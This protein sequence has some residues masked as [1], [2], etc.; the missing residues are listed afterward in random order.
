MIKATKPDNEQERLEALERYHILDTLP[1]EDYDN[2]TELASSICGTKISLITLVDNNRQFFKSK[3]GIDITETPRDIAFCAHAIH[4]PE[5]MMIVNDA[6]VDERFKDN[7]FVKENPRIGFYAGMPLVTQDGFALGTLC[8]LDTKPKVLKLDQINS[9]KRLTKLVMRLL[10]LRQ[11]TDDLSES[12]KI[13]STYQVQT[14]QLIFTI[15]HD[16]KSPV[17]SIYSFLSLLKMEQFSNLNKESR[18]YIEYAFQSSEQMTS[19]INEMLTF[20]KIGSKKQTKEIVNSEVIIEDIVKLNL[21]EIQKEN[22]EITYHD[23]NDIKTQKTLFSIVL[24]NLINNAIKYK[25]E[26]RLLQIEI[27]MEDRNSKWVIH[28]KDN[29]N[30]VKKDEL[31]KIFVPFFKEKIHSDNGIG[32]GLA[33][34]KKIVLNL[35]GDIWVNSEFGKGSTFSFSIP[36]S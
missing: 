33:V 29:G 34:C 21:P 4:N 16:L 18:Q 10:E 28:V 23:L 19:L 1:E 26:E 36:K 12:Q 30:G 6:S 17:S 24:R 7:P 11:K 22:I 3:K 9:L 32:L 5:K 27:S 2:I 15:A 14:E 20:A 31:H 8:V 35:G 13:I 25:S